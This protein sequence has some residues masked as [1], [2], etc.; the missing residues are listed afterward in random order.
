MR[1]IL[2]LDG[3]RMIAIFGVFCV[4]FRPAPKHAFD[5]TRLGW[6]G[7]DLFFAISGFLITGILLDLRGKEHSF[8]NFYW[9]RAL[10]SSQRTTSA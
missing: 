3:L 2:E 9:R 5:A 7:V 4:H 1:R 8:K 6:T 10:L